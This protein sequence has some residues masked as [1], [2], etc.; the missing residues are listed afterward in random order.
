MGV[1]RGEN[2]WAGMAWLH[3]P[4]HWS[5][6][7]GTLALR[8]GRETDFWQTTHYGFR[9]DDGHFFH[10]PAEGDFDAEVALRLV[11]NAKY[12][13]AGLMVRIDAENWLKTSLEFEPDGPSSLGAVVTNLALSD[14]SIQ[15]VG[16]FGGALRFRIE[17]RGPDYTVHAAADGATLARI[18]LARLHA[19]RGG[20]VLVGPYAC[21]PTGGGCGV[22]FEEFRLKAAGSAQRRG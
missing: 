14:W 7:G 17:R 6:E 4:P 16:R 22:V 8:T 9:R 10:G 21:S 15:P 2:V 5:V 12:D 1:E 20:A 11:P 13:Q 18:R 3:E 19:D